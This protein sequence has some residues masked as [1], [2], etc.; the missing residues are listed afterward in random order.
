LHLAQL[1][2]KL[3]LPGVAEQLEG[4]AAEAW[5]RDLLE[6]ARHPQSADETRK[7]EEQA[8]QRLRRAGDAF[9]HASAHISETAERAEVLW[10]SARDYI[11]GQSPANALQ[12]LEKIV[13]LPLAPEKLGEAW[14]VRGEAFRQLNNHVAAQADYRHCI[15][16]AGPFGYRARYQLAMYE[17]EANH[18]EEAETILTQNL[19]LMLMD[20]AKDAEAYEKTLYA[21]ANLQFNRQD[22][23]H[24]YR[25]F[26]ESLERFPNNPGALKARLRLVQCYR[27]LSQQCVEKINGAKTEDERRHWRTQGQRWVEMAAAQLQTL[28]AD[29]ATLQKTR[30]LTADEDGIARQAAFASAECQFDLGQYAEA[31]RL[32]EEL[33][34]R[35]RN[36][37]DGLIALR[38]LWQLQRLR[39]RTNEARQALD[40]IK[41]SLSQMTD[42]AFDNSAEV[43][44]RR[45]WEEW[46]REKSRPIP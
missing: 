9:D 40:A 4:Q 30:P 28:S 14:Y 11:D 39:F 32:Y 25:R 38:Y 7:I 18:L 34:G 19:E 16:F 6:Q 12:V 44:N 41:E 17:I 8:R 24:A 45:W 1:Y 33:A 20:P 27:A 31:Q 35:Y 21:L 15:K 42:D 2:E 29:L 43:C 36:Q 5:G 22:F 23:N 13:V 26:E 10:R 46:L 37:V 3:A